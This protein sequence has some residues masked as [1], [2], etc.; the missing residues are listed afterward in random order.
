MLMPQ[1]KA[2]IASSSGLQESFDLEPKTSAYSLVGL[3]IGAAR[4]TIATNAYQIALPVDSS[5]LICVRSVTQDARYSSI[6]VFKVPGEPA[7]QPKIVNFEPLTEQYGEELASYPN[8]ELSIQ[9][10]SADTIDC[11]TSR[12]TYLP[13]LGVPDGT[14]T[15]M[16]NSN[17]RNVSAHLVDPD[18]FERGD[19]SSP[20]ASTLCYPAGSSARIAFDTECVFE[21]LTSA[22]ADLLVLHLVLDD[23]FGEERQ[24]YS[25]FLP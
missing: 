3:R 10:H 8:S 15:A 12:A 9:A 25:I 22:T 11:A 24:N 18:E 2:E 19:F 21:D 5:K 6:N 1:V 7:R 14:L 16:V 13:Q 17:S 4:D 20:I 23:G